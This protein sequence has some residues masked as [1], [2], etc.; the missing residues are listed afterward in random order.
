MIYT[1]MK[2][3]IGNQLF[4]YAISRKIQE[5]RN[6][7]DNLIF[8]FNSMKGKSADDGWENSLKYFNVKKYSLYNGKGHMIMHVSNFKQRIIATAFYIDLRLFNHNDRK[9]RNEVMYKWENILLKNDLIIMGEKY[10]PIDK[11]FQ[12][13]KIFID[14]SFQNEKYFEEIKDMLQEELTPIEKPLEKNKRLYEIINNSNSVCVSIRRGDY[15]SNPLYNKEYNICNV[16]YF[17]NAVKKINT[18]VKNPVYVIFSD[19]IKWAKNNINFG[20]KTYYESGEDPIWEKL[21]LMYSCKHFIISNSSFSWWAQYL[22]RN[23]HKIVVSPDRW[24]KQDYPSYLINDSWIKI[25]I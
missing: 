25:E 8:S 15:I 6:N 18:I 2:G 21:R 11:R 4:R 5:D 20:D 17:K 16:D 23:K 3:R 14:G 12:S 24:Y 19:D 22:C 1:E 13:N 10:Y 9:I 7:I